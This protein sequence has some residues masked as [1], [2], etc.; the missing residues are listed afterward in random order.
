MLI[1]VSYDGYLYLSILETRAYIWKKVHRSYIW[2][3]YIN[4]L[5]LF[6]EQFFK[7]YALSNILQSIVKVGCL[8]LIS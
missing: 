4:R 6:F 7:A 3:L 2:N 8:G 1:L 5:M